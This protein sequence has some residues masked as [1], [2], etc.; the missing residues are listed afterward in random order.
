MHRTALPHSTS[1]GRAARSARRSIATLLAISTPFACA[2]ALPEAVAAI[3]PS[4]VAVGTFMAARATQQA[5]RG[6]GFAVAGNLAVTNAHV[7]G[8]ALDNDRRETFAIF[9]PAG[10]GRAE[11]RPARILRRDEAHDLALLR[12]EGAALPPVRLGISD[13]VREG[14]EIA[15]T[16]Y[17]ILNALGLFPA[18]HRGIVA[19]ITP[20]AIPAGSGSELTP[21]V[22]KRLGKPFDVLQLDATAYPGNSGSPVFDVATARVVGVLNSVFVKGTK[23]AALKDPS[24]IAYAIP[25]KFVR[26]LIAEQ[27]ANP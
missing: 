26:E 12:F 25:V 23:E 11:V 16:G 7:V 8:G 4:V 9:L 3:K 2:G 20:V 14:Q 18:T 6:T 17:P 22:M 13:E 10:P 27:R 21:E 19:A 5:P 1:S 15:F 24:G